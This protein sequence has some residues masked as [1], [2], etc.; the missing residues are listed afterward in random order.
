MKRN[1]FFAVVGA[2]LL[3]S[4]AFAATKIHNAIIILSTIDSTPIGQVQPDLVT[5]TGLTVGSNGTL[6]NQFI[7]GTITLTFPAI[8]VGACNEQT[9]TFSG[10]VA[11]KYVG[12]NRTAG[13]ASAIGPVNLNEKA[14]APSNG[15]VEVEICN[16]TTNAG[17]NWSGGSVTFNL[18][19]AE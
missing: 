12:I 5:T 13:T 16:T 4:V 8:N 6:V 11:S 18:L 3:A 10:V 1:T 9:G 19:V 15:N 17:L 2:L 7:Y 14:W